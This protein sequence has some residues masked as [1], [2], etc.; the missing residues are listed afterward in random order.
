M[1][2]SE[3]QYQAHLAFGDQ[4]DSGAHT[5]FCANETKYDRRMEIMLRGIEASGK[6]DMAAYL[7]D[8]SLGRPLGRYWWVKK[9]GSAVRG[10]GSHTQVVLHPALS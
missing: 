1:S 3:K 6:G 5:Y 4:R 9:A 8:P 2:K 10:L 7:P